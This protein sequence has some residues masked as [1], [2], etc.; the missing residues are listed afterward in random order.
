M[1]CV[2]DQSL[3][4]LY[5]HYV[6]SIH[7]SRDKPYCVIARFIYIRPL[8]YESGNCTICRNLCFMSYN[9]IQRRT[10]IL[11]PERC[12]ATTTKDPR[13]P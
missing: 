11:E 6:R 3:L 10:R 9:P 8:V 4:F 12:T 13:N 2:F 1:V 7:R 5:K